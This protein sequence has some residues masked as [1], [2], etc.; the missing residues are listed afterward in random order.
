MEQRACQNCKQEFTIEPEDFNYYE[1]ISVP[2]PTWCPECRM[3]RRLTCVNSWFLFWRNC[4]LCGK[5]MLSM[6]P[7]SLKLKV[8]CE[9]CWWGDSW[10]GTE[11]AMDYD[12]SRSF[13]EQVKELSEKTPYVALENT[14][15]TM[16]NCEYVNSVAYSKDCY[17]IYWADYCEFVY[18][19]SILNGLK[20]SS[21]CIRGWVSE[22]CYESV[23]FNRCYQT[24]FSDE[25]DDCVNVWF[26]R[27]CYSCINCIGCVNLRGEKNCIFNVKYSKEEY[28]KKLEELKFNSWQGLKE[29][30]K[31]AHKF[32]LTKPY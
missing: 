20:S 29:F 12:P 14:Y 27:N 24:Y 22:L 2:P 5:H 19:S 3:I 9:P 21:D 4:D 16:K 13:L 28:Q 11:Y 6:Y 17:L 15:L 18:Y 7:A 30:E 8:Y 23:G 1:K 32:W 10:D 31:K 25:C 26:S